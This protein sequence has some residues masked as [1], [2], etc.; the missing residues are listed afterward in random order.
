MS[1]LGEIEKIIEGKEIPELIVSEFLLAG[2]TVD[3]I[4]ANGEVHDLV[5]RERNTTASGI[6]TSGSFIKMMRWK[7]T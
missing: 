2:T 5:I 4:V 1:S 7:N 3:T 6:S